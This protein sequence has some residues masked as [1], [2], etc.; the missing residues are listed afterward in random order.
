MANEDLELEQLD[1]KTTFLHR[2]LKEDIYTSQP[3]G[4]SATGGEISPRMSTEKKPLWPKTSIEDVVPKVQ[5]LHP[6]AWL[7]PIRL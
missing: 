4:F 6:A 3:A 7:P 1:V 2:E 5:L